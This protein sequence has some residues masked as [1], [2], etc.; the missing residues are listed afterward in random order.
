MVGALGIMAEIRFIM[1]E[2]CKVVV[3]LKKELPPLPGRAK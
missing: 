3:S 1:R 2:W